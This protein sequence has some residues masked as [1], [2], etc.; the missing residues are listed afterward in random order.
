MRLI[1]DAMG[2][3]SAAVGLSIFVVWEYLFFHYVKVF[4]LNSKQAQDLKTVIT[5]TH[6]FKE[7]KHHLYV[8]KDQQNVVGILKVG[9]KKLFLVVCCLFAAG[10][11]NLVNC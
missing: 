2:E 10:I 11:A 8:I 5:T 4:P 6:K 9:R 1:I 3:A 7:S